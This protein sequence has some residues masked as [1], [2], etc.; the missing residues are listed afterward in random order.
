MFRLLYFAFA[1]I[2]VL[3]SFLV[4]RFFI[5][6]FPLWQRKRWYILSL[7]VFVATSSGLYISFSVKKVVNTVVDRQ[8]TQG[9]LNADLYNIPVIPDIESRDEPFYTDNSYFGIVGA[10]SRILIDSMLEFSGEYGIIPEADIGISSQLRAVQA[11]RSI[12][13]TA[14]L[15]VQVFLSLL[16]IVFTAYCVYRS[17]HGG[18][19]RYNLNV[20]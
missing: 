13:N 8:I 5:S 16:A 3:C 20:R 11:F 19:G 14:V 4:D 1:G 15:L 17:G 12:F 9:S 18:I 6:R 7:I 10:L 2:G